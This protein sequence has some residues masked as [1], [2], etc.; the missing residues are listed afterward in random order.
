MMERMIEGVMNR[1]R[2][3]M[4]GNNRENRGVKDEVNQEEDDGDNVRE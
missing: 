2:E 1:M 3:R 4:L